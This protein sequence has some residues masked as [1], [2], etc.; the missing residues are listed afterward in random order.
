MDRR[1][2]ALVLNPLS[3]LSMLQPFMQGQEGGIYPSA[4]A[5][6]HWGIPKDAKIPERPAI[7]TSLCRLHHEGLKQAE[8][9][10]LGL[11]DV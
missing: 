3:H 8:I 7:F 10:F 5:L 1:P 2:D 6:L 9:V 4:L 11:C